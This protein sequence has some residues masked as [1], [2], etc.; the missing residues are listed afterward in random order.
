MSAMPHAE[1]AGGRKSALKQGLA[2]PPPSPG[3]APGF[4]VTDAKHWDKAFRAVGRTGGG[5]RRALL[6]KLLR[7]TAARFGK[8]G[9]IKGSWLDTSGGSK[10]M[11]RTLNLAQMTCPNCGYSDD[12]AAF[13]QTNDSDD[14]SRMS[15]SLRTP[16]NPGT[17]SASGFNAGQIGLANTLDLARR[18]PVAS[19][20]DVLVSRASD[21]RGV[22]RHRRGGILIGEIRKNETGQY[23]ASFGESGH[24]LQPHTQQRGALHEL[25]G[26]WNRGAGSMYHRPQEPALIPAPS[27]TP[28]MQRFSVPA[29]SALATPSNGDSDGPR[30]TTSSS[31]GGGDL[32]GLSPKGVSI[33]KKLLKR[34]PA[35]RALAFARR[36][37]DFGGK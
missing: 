8:T 14:T 6:G 22:V 9:Q 35:E 15:A 1:T 28:L 37:Q 33:Y 20:S 25:I 11:T 31:S 17:Q 32:A 27:Q 18:T 19:A 23:V 7:K 21:G 4:P 2:L 10:D 30:M 3:A 16:V 26:T 34:M 36:A 5:A 12:D 13:S 29:V 24:D